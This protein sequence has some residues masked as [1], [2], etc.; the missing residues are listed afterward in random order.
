M[1]RT[2]MNRVCIASEAILGKK[3]FF[4]MALDLPQLL[5]CGAL[6]AA[7]MLVESC[8][9]TTKSSE[10]V[11]ADVQN[12]GLVLAGSGGAGVGDWRA[13]ANESFYGRAGR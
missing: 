9:D 4:R 3:K 10:V 1:I 7:L 13:R 8:A 11:R 2:M 12:G 6:F 5:R